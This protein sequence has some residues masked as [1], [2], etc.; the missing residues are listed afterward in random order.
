MSAG[1]LTRRLA[2]R[3]VGSDP[4]KD[5]QALEAAR[6]GVLDWLASTLA[7]RDDA[8]ADSITAALGISMLG[9][10]TGDSSVP[11]RPGRLAALD[12]ALVNGYLS[13]ALDYDD[14]HESV[15]GHPSAVILSALLAEAEER[16]STG[17]DFLAAYVV[18]VETM[19][20]LGLALGPKPYEVGWHS[21]SLL[22]VL[23]AAAACCRL[24]RL[25]ANTTVRAL[26]LAVTQ[27]GGLRV[28]FG[29]QV[30][31][32]H[33]GLAARSG[34]LA[35]R[36]AE[37]GITGAE[38]PLEGPL[39]FFAALGGV[40]AKPE[41]TTEDWGEPWQI[42]EPGL[43]F[44]RYPC[45]SA[46]HHAADAAMTI[47]AACGADISAINRVIVS[48]PPGGDAALIVS[49]PKTGVEGR[50]S[51][52]YVIAAALAD[53]ELGIGTFA[54]KPIRPDL[55]ALAAKVQ[56]RYDTDIVPAPN[57]MPKGRFTIVSVIYAD[58][59]THT[60]RVDCPRGAP[61]HPLTQEERTAKY[62]DA[63]RGLSPAWQE[64]PGKVGRLE[65]LADLY[66]LLPD[67]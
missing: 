53:G 55:L 18:G 8:G 62:A 54:D 29:T 36:L 35:M 32:L 20:R 21:T 7:A 39:G 19:C 50:F 63:V 23:A 12:A 27:A 14:V 46:S 1:L 42:A 11:G 51:V 58:G 3:I 65:Q 24:A 41:K 52:E 57:A 31:P 34:L 38:E 47:H 16:R 17:S 61:G 9:A 10:G 64:L 28:H 66:T 5:A 33:A 49:E 59:S 15:R 67:I 6:A 60:E 40:D 44:K 30:K 22:G 26:G 2:E 37:A 43:W 56:R 45:C 13:H 48:F 4:L 25:S